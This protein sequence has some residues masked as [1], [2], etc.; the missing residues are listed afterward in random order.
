M[1]RE[2]ASE[3]SRGP[4][5]GGEGASRGR[6]SAPDSREEQEQ[7]EEQDEQEQGE[8]YEEALVYVELPDF[9]GQ[10]YL[11]QAKRVVLRGLGGAGA[12][13]MEVDGSEFLGEHMVNLGSNHFFSCTSSDSASSSSAA[14]GEGDGDG[15]GE[16]EEGGS[17]PVVY[18]GHSI[19]TTE[20]TLSRIHI[21][22]TS[23][24]SSSNK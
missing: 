4:D 12:P 23:S 17:R 15:D 8:E 2:R 6:G 14:T 10:S 11:N 20:F 22:A 5:R 18:K 16:G 9:T 21:P 3:D 13:V 19:K 1:E 7:E 24:T